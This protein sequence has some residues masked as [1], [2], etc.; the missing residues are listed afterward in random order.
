MSVAARPGPGAVRDNALKPLVEPAI[1]MGDSTSP[2]GNSPPDPA[3]RRPGWHHREGACILELMRP[4]W[5]LLCVAL[6]ASADAK[7]R[8]E[9]RIVREPENRTIWQRI[10]DPNGD[11]VRTLVSKARLSMSRADDARTGDEDWAV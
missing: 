10:T 5:L 8:P 7:P 6:A 3:L 9:P 11:E 4:R 2:R 1:P